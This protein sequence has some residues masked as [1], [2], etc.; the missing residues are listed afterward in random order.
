MTNAEVL[1]D[2]VIYAHARINAAVAL[3][4]PTTVWEGLVICKTCDKGIP[5]ERCHMHN[6]VP[7]PCPTYQALMPD[8]EADRGD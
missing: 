8:E 5:T 4:Q 7:W 1:A 3:H 2:E 6:H